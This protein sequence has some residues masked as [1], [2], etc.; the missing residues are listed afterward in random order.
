MGGGEECATK[1]TYEIFFVL[2]SR[3]L[4]SIEE[5]SK[6]GFSSKNLSLQN[7]HD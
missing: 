6:L 4:N 7:K 2:S 3:M 5:L 1:S